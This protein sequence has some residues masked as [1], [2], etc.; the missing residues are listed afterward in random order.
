MFLSW[1]V[2]GTLI[3]GPIVDSLI[4]SGTGQV[5]AYRMS[6]LSAAVLVVVGM[7]VLTLVNCMKEPGPPPPPY[8]ARV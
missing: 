8:A 1:G 2:A 5:F 4:R 7:V 6:F 3:A